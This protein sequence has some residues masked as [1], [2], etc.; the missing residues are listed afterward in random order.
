MQTFSPD[1]KRFKLIYVLVF[2]ISLLI[3]AAAFSI[4]QLKSETIDDITLEDQQKEIMDKQLS[5]IDKAT[6]MEKIARVGKEYLF[7]VDLDQYAYI[8]LKSVSEIDRNDAT[9]AL[10]NESV[11][12]QEGEKEGWIE[13]DIVVF[14]NPF[15]DYIRRGELLSTVKDAFYE[16]KQAGIL[17]EITNLW[18]YNGEMGSYAK[19]YGLDAAKKVARESMED[20][21]QEI[22]ENGKSLEEASKLI[23]GNEFYSQ[24]DTAYIGNGYDTRLFSI[25]MQD[26]ED[27]AGMTDNLLEFL[28][29]A[30]EGELSEIILEQDTPYFSEEKVDAYYALYYV[31]SK[32]DSFDDVDQWVESV[33]SNYKIEKY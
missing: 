5:R 31:K 25:N 9:S 11:L 19:E 3:I 10:I 13:L 32:R 17:V 18:F 7:E 28:T 23:T 22:V 30:E 26:N 1:K 8:N 12:L 16:E 6:E 2:I 21:Y 27:I 20:V 4:W 29:S 15:K 14:N 24:L 33:K